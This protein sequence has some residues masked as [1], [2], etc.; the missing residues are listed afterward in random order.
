MVKDEERTEKMS[1]KGKK[2]IY[3]RDRTHRFIKGRA[4]EKGMPIYKYLDEGTRRKR[5]RGMSDELEDLFW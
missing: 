3:V 1:M 4:A 5:K 2:R